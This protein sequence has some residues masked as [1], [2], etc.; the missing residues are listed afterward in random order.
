[1]VIEGWR[2]A[3]ETEGLLQIAWCTSLLGESLINGFW[4]FVMM[5]SLDL[6][7]VDD[8]SVVGD[9]DVLVIV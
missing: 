4:L 6:L 2:S 9:L 5:S 1:M 3:K 7:D 8:L